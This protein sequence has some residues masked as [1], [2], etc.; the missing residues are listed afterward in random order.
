MSEADIS[1]T[2]KDML[3]YTYRTYRNHYQSSLHSMGKIG[4]EIWWQ[5]FFGHINIVI[6]LPILSTDQRLVSG[7]T[8]MISFN[9]LL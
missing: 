6:V 3:R 1:W 5:Y 4:R 8:D 2:K 9:I 7:Q